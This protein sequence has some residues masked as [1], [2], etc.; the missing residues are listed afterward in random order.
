MQILS[1]IRPKP[2]VNFTK[3]RIFNIFLIQ[4]A[5][6]S[7]EEFRSKLKAKKYIGAYPGGGLTYRYSPKN[8]KNRFFFVKFTAV[9]GRIRLK[10]WMESSFGIPN[11]G[12]LTQ[13]DPEKGG[14]I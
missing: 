14:Y 11:D 1:Q 12:Y 9:L 5:M 2:A 13:K 4:E 8:G 6:S 10:I 7:V 3:D